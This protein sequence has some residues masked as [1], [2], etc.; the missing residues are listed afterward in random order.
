M[1]LAMRVLIVV[2]KIHQVPAEFQRGTNSNAF[3][4]QFRFL[5]HRTRCARIGGHLLRVT[6]RAG[7][8]GG[9]LDAVAHMPVAT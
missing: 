7:G 6:E 4:I 3:V 1:Y 9:V 5:V 2:A 8:A